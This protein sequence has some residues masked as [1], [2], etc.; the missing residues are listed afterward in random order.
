MSGEVEANDVLLTPLNESINALRKKTRI[1]WM[2]MLFSLPSSVLA[3]SLSIVLLI[4]RGTY[5]GF[6]TFEVV[7]YAFLFVSSAVSMATMLLVP[8]YLFSTTYQMQR[9][10]QSIAFT[11]LP[12]IGNTPEQKIYNQLIRSNPILKERAKQNKITVSYDSQIKGASGVDYH[13]SVVIDGKLNPLGKLLGLSGLIFIQRLNQVTLVSTEQVKS[14]KKAVNDCVRRL[15]YKIPAR[16]IIVSTSGFDESVFEYVNT[17]EGYFK[18]LDNY[19]RIELVKENIDN[20]L[21]VISF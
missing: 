17:K 16:V 14:I 9:A 10:L 2:V 1:F 3:G 5:T 15:N 13:F 11:I 6:V 8:N 18:F 4:N 12:P 20:M 21:E 7:L 19:C